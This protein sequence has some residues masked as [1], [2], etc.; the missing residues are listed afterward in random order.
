MAYCETYDLFIQFGEE[1]VNQW[2]DLSNERIPFVVN[3]AI[4]EA[5]LQASEVI[6]SYFIDSVYTVPLVDSEAHV[7]ETVKRWCAVLAGIRLYASRG[8]L[9]DTDPMVEKEK[10]VLAEIADV[11]AGKTRLKAVK[12]NFTYPITGVYYD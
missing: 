4:E 3:A 10:R 6:D 1:N 5:I 12:S 11:L 8:Y 9:A 2:A 7:P